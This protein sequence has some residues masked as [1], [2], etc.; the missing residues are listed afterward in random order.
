[1]QTKPLKIFISALE[2]S[3]NIHLTYLLDELQNQ[4]IPFEVCGIFDTSLNPQYQSDFSSNE[5][6]IM[7][8]IGVLKLIPRLLKLKS[9]LAKIAQDCDIA[10]FM[11]SSSFNI[12]LIKEIKKHKSPPKIIYYI[13]PQ[14]WAWKAYRAEILAQICD[15]LWGILPFEKDFYPPKANL[16]YIGHPL[17]DEIPFS[18]TQPN[19]TQTLAYLPG[20]RKSEIKSLFPIF[21]E[22]AK[23][24]RKQNKQALLIIPK[25]FKNANLEEIYGDLSDFT[26]SDNLN[27]LQK[28][29][30]AFVCSGTATL[31]T[32]LMGIPT[33]LAYKAKTLD[34]WI[35][36]SLVK[37]QYIGLSNLFLQY[38]TYQD[39]T[40]K[41]E[42]PPIHPEFLQHQVNPQTLLEAYKNF[43]YT[44]FFKQKEKLITYLQQGS[45]QNCA[46][47]IKNFYKNTIN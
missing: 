43:D 37:L 38:A 45:V 28:C 30:F 18:F 2:Y 46:K 12:P 3:S 7:G 47:K 13:L 36:K 17:L 9:Q 42:N 22:I 4:N 32:T 39:F 26:L 29:E 1:M 34:Y 21:R 35:A 25:T 5:F 10:L 41:L 31:E 8:F 40:H 27:S 15:E 20:S 24:L 16:H 11:D 44:H 33:I 14:V 23:I 19:P 6:R